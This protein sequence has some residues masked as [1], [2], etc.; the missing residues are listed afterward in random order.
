MESIIPAEEPCFVHNSVVD[1]FVKDYP[2]S[3]HVA[4]LDEA[5]WR[6]VL[7]SVGSG[8]IDTYMANFPK[9]HRNDI[10][11]IKEAVLKYLRMHPDSKGA[12][13]YLDCF[14]DEMTADQ[15]KMVRDILLNA[16]EKE[17]SLND[18]S[19][20]I[21]ILR[22]LLEQPKITYSMPGTVNPGDIMQIHGH[23]DGFCYGL[24][25][26]Q[27]EEVKKDGLIQ[28][29]FVWGKGSHF[30][31]DPESSKNQNGK[32]PTTVRSET[33]R[34]EV[35]VRFDKANKASWSGSKT[36]ETPA[37]WEINW[38]HF[39]DPLGQVHIAT[40][41]VLTNYNLLAYGSS[42]DFDYNKVLAKQS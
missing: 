1:A 7:H 21:P 35:A 38:S 26:A 9:S 15:L 25:I 39:N 4:E 10:E 33:L 8:H 32:A 18:L 28:I 19:P 29:K 16:L 6:T 42:L 37:N 3:P 2:T 22:R 23:I 34:V 36:F 13:W 27:A 30:Y 40:L 14:G 12:S 11:R 17:H 41:L 20:P 24:R 5:E 31:K